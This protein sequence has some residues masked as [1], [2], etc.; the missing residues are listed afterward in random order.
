M[1]IPFNDGSSASSTSVMV[2]ATNCIE[3]P[4]T[5]RGFIIDI[6]YIY[7][8]HR[9]PEELRNLYIDL[10]GTTSI[11][12]FDDAWN[13]YE[14]YVADQQGKRGAASDI[15][16]YIYDSSTR[17]NNFIQQ[18]LKSQ[19]GW[20]K[21]QKLLVSKYSNTHHILKINQFYQMHHNSNKTPQSLTI[22][23]LSEFI[24]RGPDID[25]NLFWVD[26]INIDFAFFSFI[27]Q[28]E[29]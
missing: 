4:Q 13:S 25:I 8:Q 23:N 20:Q 19:N 7:R 18:K 9:R 28:N 24:H 15:R 26:L 3:D 6:D 10:F 11:K 17:V 12:Y 21:I 22:Y 2:R 5:R 14:K 1:Q 29:Y 27:E 16:E